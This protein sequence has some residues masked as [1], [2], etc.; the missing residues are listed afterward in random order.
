MFETIAN[1]SDAVPLCPRYNLYLKPS[2]RLL[3]SVQLSGKSQ[4]TVSNWQ[5]MERVKEWIDPDKFSKLS[6]SKISEEYVRFDAELADRTRLDTVLFRLSDRR[7]KLPGFT[8]LLTVKAAEVK[9]DFPTR[10]DWDSFYR[11]SK[12]MNELKPGE[13]PDTLHIQNIPVEWLTEPGE[14]FPSECIIKQAFEI[15]GEI[16]QIDLPAADPS[17]VSHVAGVC[18]VYIQ[19]KDYLGF[20]KAMEALKGSKL[21]Y[22]TNTKALSANIK[23]DF[24]KT[25]HMTI[26][27]VSKRLKRRE[28]FIEKLR[29]KQDEEK[30]EK[31][32]ELKK[33]EEER[34]KKLHQLEKKLER[35]K[36]RQ[37]K[38]K[39]ICLKRLADQQAD[40]M[41]QQIA[42][43]EKL[44]L[45]AQRKLEAIHLIGELLPL[46]KV[47]QTASKTNE[48]ED[49]ILCKTG[50]SDTEF[51]DIESTFR[52]RMIEKW[53]PIK[54]NRFENADF[55]N[56][57]NRGRGRNNWRGRGR[58][59]GG[60]HGAYLMP[61]I[62]DPIQLV[63]YGN[64]YQN[65]I[66]DYQAQRNEKNRSRSRSR[67]RRRKR[68]RSSTSSRSYYSTS[69]SR[70]RSRSRN[71]RRSCS[72]SRSRRKSRSKSRSRSR[73]SHSRNKSRSR[74][75]SRDYRRSRSKNRSRTHSQTRNN[76][77]RS[78]SRSVRSWTRSKSKSPDNTKLNG[79]GF[80]QKRKKSKKRKKKHKKSKK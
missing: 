5:L 67:R 56:I 75:W 16:T 78:Y 27:S 50:N 57:N 24:D 66:Q 18:D 4:T 28:K 76:R 61:P 13:R 74:S 73:R 65:D 46:L 25:K 14:N 19:Y 69:R 8:N 52:Q 31:E 22:I 10:H 30:R 38:R 51:K 36:L 37:A 77:S 17:R 29:A 39:A 68:S 1:Q 79:S 71:R 21:A 59:R 15:Y 26:S 55:R 40:T 53:K 60:L 54:A 12:D 32:K 11:D 34:I 42:T 72:R 20:A 9:P 58:G 80:K 63:K 49:K 62:F 33:I 70:S 44:L 7:I 64:E 23:V 6:V 45:I 47:N 43:E 3:I 35:R 48:N 2:A 41:N